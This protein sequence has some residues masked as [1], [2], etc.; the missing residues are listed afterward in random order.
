MSATGNGKEVINGLNDVDKRYI[1]QLMST[2]QL[3]GSIIFGSQIQM[4][5]GTEKYDVSLAKDS[6]Q[7]L[8]KNHLKDGFID[9]GRQKMFMERKWTERQYNVQGNA[10]VK[11]KDL[12]MY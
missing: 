3:P 11:H 10:D 2:F 6:Q 8:T 7:H 9:Q 1:N 4:H 5:T 12:K